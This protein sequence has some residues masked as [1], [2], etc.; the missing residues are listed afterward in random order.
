MQVR[1]NKKQKFQVTSLKS[2]VSSLKLQD[3]GDP[4]LCHV[5]RGLCRTGRTGP[6]TA[7]TMSPARCRIFCRKIAKIF[8][9]PFAFGKKWNI[10]VKNGTTAEII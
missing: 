2:Q 6:T 9:K 7:E 8:K 4:A 1:Y 3:S 10:M 5:F